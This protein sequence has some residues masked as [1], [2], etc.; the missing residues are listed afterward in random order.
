MAGAQTGDMIC[1]AK[2]K[3]T[4]MPITWCN[5]CYCPTTARD[6]VTRCFDNDLHA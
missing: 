4:V 5:N 3:G 1:K 2:I 6:K